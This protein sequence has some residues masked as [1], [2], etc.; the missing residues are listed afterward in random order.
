MSTPRSLT[1]VVGPSCEAHLLTSL[2][3]SPTC[4]LH[5]GTYMVN[6]HASALVYRHVCGSWPESL[7]PKGGNV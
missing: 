3:K 1:E 5:E 7:F 2:L 4:S 6:I